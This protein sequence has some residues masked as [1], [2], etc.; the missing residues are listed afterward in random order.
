MAEEDIDVYQNSNNV[1]IFC[2]R[3]RHHGNS[4][5]MQEALERKRE[6]AFWGCNKA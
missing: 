4:P 1:T 6:H 2:N 5:T 3:C